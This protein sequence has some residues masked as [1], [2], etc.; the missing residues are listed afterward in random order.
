MASLVSTNILSAFVGCTSG[1]TII[2][3]EPLYTMY[4]LPFGISLPVPIKVTGT[5]GTLDFAAILNAPCK[6][7]G[8]LVKTIQL[9]V[10]ETVNKH[11]I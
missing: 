6:N 5:T 2:V 9:Y 10:C 4:S 3:T 7:V 11:L 8:N 1:C